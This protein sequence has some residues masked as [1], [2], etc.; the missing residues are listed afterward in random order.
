MR[1]FL[2]LLV[3]IGIAMPAMADMD[4]RLITVTGRAE[5]T[6]KPDMATITLG[7]EAARKSASDAMAEVSRGTAAVFQTLEQAGIEAR[8]I[9][10][11]GLNLYMVWNNSS[12]T[13][14]RVDGF[15]ASNMVTVRV[16]DLDQLGGILDAVI[17]DGANRF[18]GVAFGLQDPDPA[19][20]EAR[21]AAVTEARRKAEL[22]AVAAGVELGEL[23]SLSE[24]GGASP[25]PMPM[26]EA[27]RSFA[28][29]VPI[30]PGE[31]AVSA[32]VSL[33]YAIE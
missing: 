15:N 9:Q 24:A 25:S 10:T 22:Y 23:Q 26:M 28:A 30:A 21:K 4:K 12:G 16:R 2:T 7:V 27:A 5:V 29:D 32:Q 17:R 1:F 33:V 19:M 18:Q 6:A 20:D 11:S 31:L 14:R 3:A 8:D 13:N